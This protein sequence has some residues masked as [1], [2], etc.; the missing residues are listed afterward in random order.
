V[1]LGL[2]FSTNSQAALSYFL[3]TRF[4]LVAVR[5]NAYSEGLACAVAMGRVLG[6]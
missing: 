2:S 6:G 5:S 3:V 4:P 1:K